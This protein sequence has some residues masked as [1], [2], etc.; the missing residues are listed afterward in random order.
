MIRSSYLVFT[1]VTL[2]FITGCA[3]MRPVVENGVRYIPVELWTGTEWDGTKQLRMPPVNIISGKRASRTITGPIQWKHPKTGKQLKVY[4]RTKSKRS[5]E[6]KQL[7]AIASNRSGLGRVFDARPGESDR[8]FSDEVIFPL[9][10]WKRGEERTFNF[11]E[12]TDRGPVDRVATI[13]IRRLDF[14][15]KGAY[16]SLKFDWTLRDEKGEIVFDERYIYSPGAGLVSF[17]NRL[18]K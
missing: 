14:K 5:G 15:Y 11:V 1:L 17:K 18:A 6:K 8:Y 16:H 13:K 12:Y 7:Y 9:G 10:P 4:Q 2:F 3:S